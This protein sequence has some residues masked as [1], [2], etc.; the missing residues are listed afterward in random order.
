MSSL[1]EELVRVTEQGVRTV[2][3]L[4]LGLLWLAALWITRKP[5]SR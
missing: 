5:V 3:T 1:S 2:E 4:V